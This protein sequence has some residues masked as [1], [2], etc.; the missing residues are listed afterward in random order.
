MRRLYFLFK[1]RVEE[2]IHSVRRC[3]GQQSE[4]AYAWSRGYI[5]GLLKALAILK[6]LTGG[7]AG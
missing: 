2:E 5:K 3:S 7:D 1:E 6:E 4:Q